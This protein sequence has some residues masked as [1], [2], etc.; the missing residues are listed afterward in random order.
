MRKSCAQPPHNQ[1]VTA[2]ITPELTHKAVYIF[3][4]QVH[5]PHFSTQERGQ[6]VLFYPQAFALLFW[7]FQSVYARFVHIIHRAYKN[8]NYLIYI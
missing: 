1:C 7:L 2:R 5:K 4:P 6:T 8:D 3:V